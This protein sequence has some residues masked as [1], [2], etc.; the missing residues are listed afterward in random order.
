[1]FS[2]IMQD[3]RLKMRK[4]VLSIAMSLDG[5]IADTDGRVDWLAG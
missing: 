2:L 4:I 1:M 5:Y 3:R